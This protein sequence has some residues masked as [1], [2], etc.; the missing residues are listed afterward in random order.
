MFKLIQTMLKTVKKN[1]INSIV[2]SIVSSHLVSYLFNNIMV[3]CDTGIPVLREIRFD[4]SSIGKTPYRN[5]VSTVIENLKY[6]KRCCR[7]HKTPENPKEI[8]YEI[9]VFD[10][11]TD[12]SGNNHVPYLVC[13]YNDRINKCLYGPD[14][15]KQLL[16]SIKCDTILL[17]PNAS[18]DY[19]F[20]VKY[21]N[22]NK[23][24]SKG[25]TRLW[26]F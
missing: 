4:N 8:N 18:Y 15:G 11:E 6:P 24:T 7:K 26:K 13:C 25:N 3:Y 12:T 9:L 2:Q 1:P 5:N 19:R 23:V 21:F 22:N 14:C 16:D 17:A 20:L 10:F